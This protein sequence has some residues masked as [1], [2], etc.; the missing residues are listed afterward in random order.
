MLTVLIVDDERIERSFLRKILEKYN[1]QYLIVGEAGTGNEAV[2]IAEKN[3]PDIII[4]DINMP[5]YNGLQ[6]A[7]LIKEKSPNQIIILNSA[8]AEF[9]FAQQAVKY[10]LDA[11]LLKPAQEEE[12]FPQLLTVCEKKARA[13]CKWIY[14]TELFP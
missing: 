3:K 7:K 5:F 6:A 12:S 11:Y 14:F 2:Q 4:M 13:P 10:N 8:Y 1:D 9:E